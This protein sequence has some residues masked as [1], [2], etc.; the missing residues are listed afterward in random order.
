VDFGVPSKTR[1][2][3]SQPPHA[4]G[5]SPSGRVLIGEAVW[6][7]GH[8]L[9]CQHTHLYPRQMWSGQPSPA[10]A[11]LEAAAGDK[12]PSRLHCAQHQGGPA[13]SLV[14]GLGRLGM[15]AWPASREADPRSRGGKL[16]TLLVSPLPGP[17]LGQNCV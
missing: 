1:P 13:E 4:R 12:L 2:R 11:A 6:G 16:T 9:G 15:G 3:V 7:R 17:P 8:I 5:P 10:G 14:W